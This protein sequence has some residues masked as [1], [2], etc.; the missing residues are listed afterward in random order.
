MTEELETHSSATDQ[1][2]HAESH[3]LKKAALLLTIPCAI[4]PIM[5]A[6]AGMMV[7]WSSPLLFSGDFF[8]YGIAYMLY[9]YGLLLSYRVHRNLVP[10]A[11][12]SLH[13]ACL[14][15]YILAGQPE[16][17]GYATVFS[18]MLTSIV[19]QYFRNGSLDCAECGGHACRS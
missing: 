2:F 6:S 10:F 4:V 11:L 18:L 1:S 17:S 5:I 12:I 14:A 3:P 8:L 16:W 13:L 9:L 19:N 7:A 15:I